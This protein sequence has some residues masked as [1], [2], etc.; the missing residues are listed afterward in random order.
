LKPIGEGFTQNAQNLTNSSINFKK[1]TRMKYLTIAL[2]ILLFANCHSHEHGDGH[3]HGEAH[4][5]SGEAHHEDE[6]ALSAEQLKNI[7]LQYGK[8]N[9]RS[10]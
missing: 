4:D 6:I 9:P 3:D 5:D 7:G 10:N 8:S 2:L 1:T